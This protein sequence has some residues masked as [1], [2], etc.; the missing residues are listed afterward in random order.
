MKAEFLAT[1]LDW[2]NC[3]S[4]NTTYSRASGDGGQVTRTTPDLAPPLL[5]STPMEGLLSLDIFNEH[6][7]PL[8]DRSSAVLDS[9]L[10][11]NLL[12][13]LANNKGH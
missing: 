8:L 12:L 7:L 5:T 1:I 13:Q 6:R 2:R 9:N 11:L 4:W 3:G 10:Q